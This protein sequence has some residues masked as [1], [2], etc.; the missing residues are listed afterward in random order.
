MAWDDAGRFYPPGLSNTMKFWV[1]TPEIFMHA[2][3][4]NMEF[5][6]Q[7]DIFC[8]SRPDRTHPAVDWTAFH[9]ART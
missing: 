8:S 3:E 6:V 4:D 2:L 5:V 9:R 7:L 1:R